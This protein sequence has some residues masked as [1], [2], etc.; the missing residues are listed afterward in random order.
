MVAGWEVDL[1]GRIARLVEAADAEIDFSVED[2]RAVRVAI[3]A[4]VARE[5]LSIRAIDDRLSV[6]TRAIEIDAEFIEI[7]QSRARAGLVSELD[8][9]RAERTASMN[10]AA[11]EPLRGERRAAEQRIAVLLGERPGS[12]TISEKPQANAP[13]TPGLGLPAEL[14]ARRPDI[15]SAERAYAAAVARIGAAQAD[16]YPRVVFGGSFVLGGT[17]LGDLGDPDTRVFSFGPRVTVPIFDGGRIRSNFARAE[18]EA[19]SAHLRLEQQ[20]LDA[21]RDVET[22]LVRLGRARDRIAELESAFVSARDSEQLATS[23]YSAGNIDFINVLEA[24]TE[25]LVIEELL[26]TAKL[27]VLNE[28]VSLSV[29]LGGGWSTRTTVHGVEAGMSMN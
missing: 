12:V 26:A 15:R 11:R 22:S 16:R 25:R 7:V 14:L 27:D 23:L 8:L 13:P 9:L 21:V 19:R 5:V 10:R 17:D 3:A 4:E 24:R 29:A 18:S 20:V 1:W 2:Y 28:S 6:L